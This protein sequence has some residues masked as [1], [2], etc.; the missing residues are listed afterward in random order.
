MSR[1]ANRRPLTA[2]TPAARPDARRRLF[3][4]SPLALG[5]LGALGVVGS[6][7]GCGGGGGEPAPVTPPAG[8]TGGSF[9]LGT[10]TGFGSIIVNGIRYDDSGAEVYDDHG[11]RRGRDDLKL[12]AKVEIEAR[13]LDRTAGTATATV[14]RSR[15]ELK[16]P[17]ASIDLAAGRLVVLGQTVVVDSSTVFDDSLGGGL[18]A[19]SVGQWVEV[20]GNYDA[21]QSL[22]LATRIER[23]DD[24]PGAYKLR[25]PVASLDTTART[26]RL[27]SLVISY[28]NLSTLP[29]NLANGLWVRVEVQTTPVGGVWLATSLSTESS[30][31]R[32]DHDEAEVEGTITAFTSVTQFSVNGLPVDASGAVFEDGQAGIVLGARVEVEGSWVN[33]VL[34]ARKVEIEGRSGSGSGGSDDDSNEGEFELHGTIGSLDTSAKTFVLRGWVV[35]YGGSVT[36]RDGSEAQLANGVAVE[37]KGNLTADGTQLQAVRISFED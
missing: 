2:A 24:R 37:V 32:D 34:V 28:A 3:C 8:N 20:H 6:L 21:A 10:I 29:A 15:S 33:G 25:G 4:L 35:R 7:T 5:G 26:F 30:G 18:A 11:Q 14:I 22:Y 13:S 19:L 12:G 27:G 31:G 1:P 9:A 17:I 16:G 23:E 36:Y